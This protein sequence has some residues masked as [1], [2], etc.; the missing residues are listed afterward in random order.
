MSCI[1][2]L[3]PGRP[4][5]WRNTLRQLLT[6]IRHEDILLSESTWV[7][8][9][10]L[11]IYILVKYADH[12]RRQDTEDDVVQGHVEVCTAM[13]Q[14]VAMRTIGR[15]LASRKSR[16]ELQCTITLLRTLRPLT[17]AHPHPSEFTC[18]FA[19]H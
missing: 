15:N 6:Q 2:K 19:C 11:S 12:K 14:S 10:H 17:L 1:F 13:R 8:A 5:Y 3:F 7:E 16:P 18:K 9:A 4:S